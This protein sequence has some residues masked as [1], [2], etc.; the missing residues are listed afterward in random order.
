[1]TDITVK[2]AGN[3]GGYLLPYLKIICNDKNQS[4]K[5]SN[6]IKSTKTKSPTGDSGVTTLPPTGNAFMYIETSSNSN[7]NNVFVSFQRSDVIQITNITFCFNRFL[8]LIND[9]INR[10][11]VLDFNSY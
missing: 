5:I 10:W 1:M 6:F 2:K 7:G 8:I 4:G 11:V 9:S 3:T